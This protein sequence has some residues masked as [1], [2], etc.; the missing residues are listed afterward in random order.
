MSG[1]FHLTVSVIY[2]FITL[3]V[4]FKIKNYRILLS[5]CTD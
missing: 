1:E 3:Y 5:Y 2:L 4:W